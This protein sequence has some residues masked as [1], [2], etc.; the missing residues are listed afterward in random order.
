MNQNCSSSNHCIADI[1]QH[2]CRSFSSDS[3]YFSYCF[4]KYFLCNDS[5]FIKDCEFLSD[6]KQDA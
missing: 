6:V 2:Y 1:K 5:Y 4:I 3:D